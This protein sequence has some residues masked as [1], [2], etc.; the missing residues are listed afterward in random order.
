MNKKIKKIIFTFALVLVT[1]GIFKNSYAAAPLPPTNIRAE[2]GDS[3]ATISF[4]PDLTNLGAG[5]T[6]VVTSVAKSLEPIFSGTGASSPVVVTGLTNGQS[7]KFVVK[8]KNASG[9]SVNSVES[10]SVIPQEQPGSGNPP[11]GDDTRSPAP[12]GGAKNILIRY[13]NPIAV[14]DLE[15]FMAKIID[16]AVLLLTPIIVIMLIWT[17]FLFISARGNPESLASAKKA[18]LY[19]LIGATIILIAKGFSLA[20]RGVFSQF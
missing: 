20:I 6:Y 17:G 15:G 16:S 12:A 1:F 18:L 19:V 9:V 7:Y 11:S 14:D 10:N 5:T 3:K 2:A 13:V 8:A 4:T